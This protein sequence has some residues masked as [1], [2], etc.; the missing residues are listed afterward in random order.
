MRRFL[1]LFILLP[2][3]IVAVI[4]SVANRQ[5]VTLRVSPL[6]DELSA[7]SVSAPLF[8]I[9]FAVLALGVV[10]GGGATWLRQSKWRHA[11]RAERAK[12]EQLRKDVERLRE[13]VAA[14]QPA[15]TGPR[16]RD[17]A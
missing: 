15:L 11:A 14:A 5:M 13:R 2:I 9:L 6:A 10:A 1:Y 4:V 16:E 8:V 3:A 12:S 17:A 7:W